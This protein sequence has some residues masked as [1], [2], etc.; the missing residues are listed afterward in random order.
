[1]CSQSKLPDNAKRDINIE[2]LPYCAYLLT[3]YKN[4]HVG[5]P[6]FEI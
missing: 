5:N 4:M 6:I 3:L 2:C 1:M